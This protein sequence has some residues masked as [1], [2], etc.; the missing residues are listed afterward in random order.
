MPTEL[1]FIVFDV[2]T[3]GL[4]PAQDALIEVAAMRF[5]ASGEACD[6]FHTLVRPPRGYIPPKIQELTRIRPEDVRLAPGPEEVLPAFRRW[7]GDGLF[8]MLAHNAPFDLDFLGPPMARL[9]LDLP[10]APVFDTLVMARS[11]LPDLVNHKLAT[12]GQALGLDSD[13]LHRADADGAL[14]KDIFLSLR[15]LAGLHTLAALSDRFPPLRF[16]ATPQPRIEPDLLPVTQE[17]PGFEGLLQAIAD[18]QLIRFI[19]QGGRDPGLAR[20]VVPTRIGR[21]GQSLYLKGKPPGG[22]NE[23]TYKLELVSSWQVLESRT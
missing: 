7:L 23:L 14:L 17:P 15:N 9:G 8:P 20:T 13:T 4:S 11:L 1:E 16:L 19:Y 5:T 22:S 2:E 6:T 18:R 3:T 10:K 21:L 12:V